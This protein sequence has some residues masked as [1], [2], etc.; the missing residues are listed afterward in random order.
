MLN[1]CFVYLVC[2][3]AAAACGEDPGQG[4]SDAIAVSVHSV[5]DTQNL[6]SP[7]A[8]VRLFENRSSKIWVTVNG[9]VRKILPDDLEGS[10]HQ[11]LI[12]ELSNGHTLL[13]IH[14]ID[15]APR[16]NPVRVNDVLTVHGR[17]EWNR[18]GGVVHWTHHDPQGRRPGGWIRDSLRTYR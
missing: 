13:I 6:T 15:V 4:R 11:R 18:H 9:R 5:N 2:L 10:R 1:R 17:Y 12:L 16:V 14:N 7:E 8:V 3:L